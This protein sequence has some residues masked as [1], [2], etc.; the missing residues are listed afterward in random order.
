MRTRPGRSRWWLLGPLFLVLCCSHD[1][2]RDNPLDPHLTP[3]VELQVAVDDAAY[4]YRVSVVNSEGFEV[5]SAP[6]SIAL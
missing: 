5:S 2:P 6:A 4:M 3:P 1:A